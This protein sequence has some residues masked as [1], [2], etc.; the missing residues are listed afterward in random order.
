MLEYLKDTA[1]IVPTMGNRPELLEQCIESI[2]KAGCNVIHV[3]IPDAG[4]VARLLA[5]GKIS[6][7]VTDPMKGLAAAINAG[8]ESLPDSVLYANWLG[9][10][11]LL[12]S[13]S[14]I[15]ARSVLASEPS[16]PLVFGACEY[17]DGDGNVI[18]RSASGRWAPYLMY[19][20]PQMVPQPGS[21][22]RV[23]D[24][25]A[26]GGLDTTYKFAFDLDLLMKLRRLGSFTYVG[27]TLSKFRWHADSLS[28]GGRGG[29]VSEASQIRRK[30][31]PPLL[32][33]LSALWEPLLRMVILRAGARVTRRAAGL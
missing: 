30:H 26:V 6:A 29:S 24:F 14:V 17:I 20:G 16:T 18:F 9:D 4:K 21:L 32:R 2:H 28:V 31:L 22:F 11:D 15:T 25:R 23:A 1:I 7:V 27:Q 10:D 8:I 19:A 3:V 33:Q 12:T 5:E 13:G